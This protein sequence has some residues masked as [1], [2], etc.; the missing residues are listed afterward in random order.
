MALDSSAVV[1]D[2]S[3]AIGGADCAEEFDVVEGVSVEPGTV[4]V[5]TSEGALRPSSV[6][7]DNRVAGVVSGAGEYEPALV[8]DRQ[9]RAPGRARIA[10]MGKAYCKV[11]AANGP[12]SAGDLLTTSLSPGCAMPVSD[13]GRAVGAVIGKALLPWSKG[14]GLIPILV[15]LQ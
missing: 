12:I 7:Y 6:A 8:L 1:C 5:L 9:P 10:L 4:M 3:A 15:A 14:R 11:D 2:A 13:H